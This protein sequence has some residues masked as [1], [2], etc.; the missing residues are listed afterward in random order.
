RET[1]VGPWF[2]EPLPTDRWRP[3]PYDDPEHAAQLAD[4]VSMAALLLLERLSPLERAVFVLRE[5]FQFGFADVAAAVGRSE[6][7]CRQLVSRARRAV[8]G[9]RRRRAVAPEAHRALLERFL[10]AARHGDLDALESLLADDAV[11]LS[12]GG[13]RRKA[14]R[15]PILGR[16]RVARFLR[17]VGPRVLADH[18]EPATINGAPGFRAYQAGA[19]HLVG[20]VEVDDSQVVAVHW[21]LNPDKLRWAVP[22]DPPQPG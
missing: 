12:D 10:A 9:D 5:V 1:Y 14:A 17:R 13:P 7:A 2:P 11:L 21:V 4:S 19:L 18:V 15:H 22:P 6:A 20:T 3:E 16:D 8:R